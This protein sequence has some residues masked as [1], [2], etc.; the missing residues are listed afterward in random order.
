MQ[1]NY[2]PM[3]NLIMILILSCGSLAFSQTGFKHINIQGGLTY[4]LDKNFE[5][6]LE[7]NR[8]YF[9]SWTV[10]FSAFQRNTEKGNQENYTTGVYY[11]NNLLAS[12]NSFLNVKM[13]SS[14]GT[15][16][17]TFVFDLILGLEYDYAITRDLKLSFLFKNNVMFK[18]DPRFRHA[19]LGGLKFRI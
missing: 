5:I 11:S 17:E 14:L 19:L 18:A 16:S 3:K 13:G 2:K 7:F 1:I 4:E 9:N 8:K 15:N 12:K 10:F 6:G